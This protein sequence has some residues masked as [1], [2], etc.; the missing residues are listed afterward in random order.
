MIHAEHPFADLPEDR[1]PVRRFRGRLVSPVTI[2]TSGEG[3]RR[4]GLTVSSLFVSE[5]EPGRLHAIVGP[6]TDLWDVAAETERFVVHVCGVDDTSLAEVFAGL[7]PS[8]GGLFATTS[9]TPSKWGPVVDEIPDR[10]F[11]SLESRVESGNSG[12]LA[13]FVDGVELSDIENPHVHFRGTYR[14]LTSRP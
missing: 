6:N 5:G 14:S 3:D 1:D 8:P 9:T 4:T 10:L 11:C 2:F 13:G 12:V 7:R